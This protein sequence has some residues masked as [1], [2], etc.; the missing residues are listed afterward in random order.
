MLASNLEITVKASTNY[1]P[2]GKVRENKN[3]RYTRNSGQYARKRNS[4]T[5]TYT[6]MHS[7]QRDY[8]N[9]SKERFPN[10]IMNSYARGYNSRP[11]DRYS[12]KKQDIRC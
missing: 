8:N 2:V 1:I 7:N 10:R 4:N 11:T 12:N 6:N 3:R 5:N 9:R